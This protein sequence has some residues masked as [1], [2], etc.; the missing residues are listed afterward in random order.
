MG[1]KNQRTYCFECSNYCS[2][3]LLHYHPRKK[4]LEVG[5]IGREIVEDT[6]DSVLLDSGPA[7]TYVS[8]VLPALNELKV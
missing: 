1:H 3:H 6:T 2:L 4:C 5:V 8:E 7:T